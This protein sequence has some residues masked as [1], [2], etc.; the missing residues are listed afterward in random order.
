M[1]NLENLTGAKK[2]NKKEQQIIK[3]GRHEPCTS[4]SQCRADEF[5]DGHVCLPI[6]LKPLID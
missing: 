3:G 1:K 2:L 5:C 4:D 6:K